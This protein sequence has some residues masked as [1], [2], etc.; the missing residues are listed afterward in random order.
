MGA[1]EIC[2]SDRHAYTIIEVINDKK[3]VV[4]QDKA[5]RTDTNGMSDAQSYAFSPDPNGPK[6]TLTLRKNGRWVPVGQGM[7]DDNFVI[8]MRQE[9]YDYSF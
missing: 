4:Q 2:W 6:R 7:N 9:Y 1:T 5:T 8:G 3:I